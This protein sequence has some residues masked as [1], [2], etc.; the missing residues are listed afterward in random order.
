[1]AGIPLPDAQRLDAAP[2]D[3]SSV[4][5]RLDLSTSDDSIDLPVGGYVLFLED[6]TASAVL[7]C[8]G[9][10]STPSNKSSLDGAFLLQPGAAVTLRLTAATTLHGIMRS[11][12]GKLIANKVL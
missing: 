5:Y 9:T 8:G 11:S 2:F 6:A 10:A 1:M 3:P 7:C 12:T 4:L